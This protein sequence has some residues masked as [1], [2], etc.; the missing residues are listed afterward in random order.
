[1]F[2]YSKRKGTPAA[3]YPDQVLK[4][5][6][7]QRVKELLVV[8]RDSQARFSRS[9]IGKSVDVL[10]ERVDLKGCAVGHTPH[11]IQV[12]IPAREDGK[13]WASGGFVTVVLEEYHIKLS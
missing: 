4:Q 9:F 3:D 1:M 10:I 2:P 5:L 7:D 13:L 6:K 8:A 11:Y 12:E